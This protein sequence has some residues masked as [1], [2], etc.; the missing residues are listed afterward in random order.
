V[1]INRL[2]TAQCLKGFLIV[3][4]EGMRAGQIPYKWRYS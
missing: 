1:V 3:I 2:R 4:K